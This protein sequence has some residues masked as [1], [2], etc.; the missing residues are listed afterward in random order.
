[1][2]NKDVS[3]QPLSQKPRRSQRKLAVVVIG[4]L[5]LLFFG[6]LISPWL[7]DV[8]NAYAYQEPPEVAAISSQLAM[9]S[10]GRFLFKA[11]QPEL[12]NRD[13]FNQRCQQFE[14]G[15]SIL[16]CYSS[17]K[18]YIFDID[19]EKLEGSVIVTTAHELLHAVYERLSSTD[20][21]EL[22]DQLDKVYQDI[23]SPDLEKRMDMYARNEPG[24]KYNELHSIIGTEV[25]D[26]PPELEEHYG[27]YFNDRQ[28]LVAYELEYRKLFSDLE[29]Q[30][31]ALQQWLSSKQLVIT[32]Q[33]S[34]YEAGQAAY[35]RANRQL[36]SDSRSLDRTDEA[37]VNDYNRRV[38]QLNYQRSQLISQSS[39]INQL[40][41]QYNRKVE[42]FNRIN[43]KAK[44]LFDSMNSQ[45]IQSI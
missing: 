44:G 1:M 18:I 23:K 45:P 15:T 41:D 2:L 6:L 10:K 26:L 20:R 40:I 31:R 17:G 38:D 14:Q 43:D 39:Y 12:L 9:T 21:A 4:A 13:S 11:S 25:A 24:Q 34:E 37:A 16:G 36:Q 33:M 29:D 27:T 19:D 28:Q 3:E 32:Q 22:E 5:L 7:R 30:A 35:D 8:S 42:E